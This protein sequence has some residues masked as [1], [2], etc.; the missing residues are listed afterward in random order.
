MEDLVASITAM[1]TSRMRALHT[2]D[3][4][5]PVLDDPW[6]DR[7]IPASM[8]IA[9]VA[10][11]D[12]GAYDTVGE[13]SEEELISFSDEV[14]RVSPAF[15]NV[16]LR[17]RY[18]EDALS[19]AIARGVK[20]YVLIGAGFDSYA[21]RM[22]S[23]AS[24]LKVIEVDHPATQALKLER[25]RECGVTVPDGVQFVAADLSSEG[26]DDAL[27]R[28]GFDHTTEAFFSWLG[29]TMYLS[30]EAN[31]AT[32]AKIAA[33][34]AAGSQ[35]VFSYLDQKLFEP[36]GT[37]E[38][39]LF[40]DLEQRVKSV[41]EPFVSGFYPASLRADLDALGLKLQEDLNEFELVKRYDPDGINGLKPADRS[42]VALV[43]TAE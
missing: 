8:L 27:A 42:H 12:S 1:S 5:Q 3:D 14:L 38:A 33:C 37:S 29:V 22:P 21:L 28:S 9:A 32:L 19:T 11:R 4:P 20:Q 23:Q 16:I 13:A 15:T 17:S 36:D 30:R 24:G 25:I 40:D 7:L 41:G 31:M 35:L 6:G 2:R 34:S 18:T 39:A 10:Q 26:L 43:R